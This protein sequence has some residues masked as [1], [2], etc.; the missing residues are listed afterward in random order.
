[1]KLQIDNLQLST[2]LELI[3]LQNLTE[4]MYKTKQRIRSW[5]KHFITLHKR[6]TQVSWIKRTRIRQSYKLIYKRV[7]NKTNEVAAK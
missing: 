7:L 3:T 6:W 1:M 2:Y 5:P 4:N